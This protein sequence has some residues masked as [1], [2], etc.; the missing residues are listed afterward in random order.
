MIT[1]PTAPE[2][3]EALAEADAAPPGDA[4]AAFLARVADN[5]R[6]TLDRETALAPGAEAAAIARLRTL[7]GAEGEFEAL[8][9]ELCARLRD[10]RLE[11]LGPMLLAHL[12]AC[13]VDQISID[14]PTY[15]GLAALQR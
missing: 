6:A 9:A 14:Q 3:R 13:V 4:R 5:A 2:L 11:P 10:G 15:G 7:L 12:R 1:H 8:N